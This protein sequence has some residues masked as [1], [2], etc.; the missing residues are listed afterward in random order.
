MSAIAGILDLY[1]DGDILRNMLATMHCRGQQGHG[2]YQWQSACLLH[3]EQFAPEAFASQPMVLDWGK[4]RYVITFDGVLYNPE[5]LRQELIKL[6][7][8]LE[9]CHH[10]ELMLHA[11]ACWKEGAMEKINGIFAFAILEE[12]SGR[13]FLAR[14]RIGVKP[15]FYMQHQGGLLFAS[16][17]KTVLA[18]PGASRELD[19]E[20]AAQLLLLGPG[21]KMGS[22]VFHNMLELK[23]GHCGIYEKG[24]LTLSRYW[25]LKDRE[26][27]E[28]FAETCEH[29]RYLVLDAI[30]RQ[31]DTE[32]S[33]GT[34]LSGGLDSSLI[35]AVCGREWESRGQRLHTFSVDYQDNELYFRPGKFQPNADAEYIRLMQSHLD[36]EHHWTV[37][38]TQDLLADLQEATLARDL[39]GMADV[40]AS[41]LAFCRQ[42]APHVQVA[43]SGECAD[44][45]FGG[46]PW[47]R[48]HD[49]KETNFFP[50]ANNTQQRVNLLHPMIR[51]TMDGEGYIRDCINETLHDCDILPGSLDVR[52]KQMM[53]LNL[54]WFMQTLIDRN[55]RMSSRAGLQVRVPFCDYRIVEYLY[56]VPWTF[57]DHKGREKGLLR[58]AVRDILPDAV[59]F[60]KKSPY[61]KTHHPAY[62]KAVKQRLETVLEDP[63]APMFAIVDRSAVTKLVEEDFATPWY[64][65]LMQLPQT[66]VYL[67]Q[68]N[69]WMQ[70]YS[71]QFR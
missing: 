66:I 27:T 69:E 70:H 64:G 43:L 12:H 26:H 49:P 19:E 47:Y 59:L 16:E 71:V 40:D 31:M 3:A 25:K 52:K 5:E 20:G 53:N 56:G 45:I 54:W 7:H 46:Y 57:M 34:F 61:P 67:L 50:W 48:A 8:H 23:P 28:D 13:V 29:V 9:S 36:S 2:S 35:S 14:D 22:G 51:K 30:H 4:E 63:N 65:Q 15:L 41:L 37:L 1:Y 39:P 24:K 11:Y 18:Y 42:V 38:T 33:L 55:D 32:N 21:R 60:R 68:I 44:E 62:T 17:M 58:H 10:A 6:G